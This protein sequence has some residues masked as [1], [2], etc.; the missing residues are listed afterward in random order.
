MY[1]IEQE[2]SQFI[3]NSLRPQ[4][5]FNTYIIFTEIKKKVLKADLLFIRET[6]NNSL[7]FA[8]I[9]VCATQE[10]FLSIFCPFHIDKLFFISSAQYICF[11]C[12]IILYT[13]M[14]MDTRT[15]YNNKM[16]YRCSNIRTRVFCLWEYIYIDVVY[17]VYMWYSTDTHTHSAGEC[18]SRQK[19]QDTLREEWERERA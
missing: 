13:G 17:G 14:D 6:S 10:N 4:F 18:V 16:L 1:G 7:V 3:L 12:I 11:Y 9:C 19:L 15:H 8:V 5:R 2:Q